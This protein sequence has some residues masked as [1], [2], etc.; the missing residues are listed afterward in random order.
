M[1]KR[2]VALLAVAALALS[3]ASALA[4]SKAT[5]GTAKTSLGTVLVAAN[6][7][8]LYLL[9]NETDKKLVCTG[10]C[11]TYWPPLMASGRATVSGSAKASLLGTVK[12]GSGE[13]VTYAGH[14]L[15]YYE[16]DT[17]AGQVAGQGIKADGG[18]WWALSASGSPAGSAA[19][20]GKSAGSSSSGASGW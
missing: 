16:A 11:L 5:V 8:T 13:Q 7:H 19:K 4:T 20:S 9:S 3:A 15:Y 6:G 17:R 10:A 14:P 1:T 18:T 2:L 12:R